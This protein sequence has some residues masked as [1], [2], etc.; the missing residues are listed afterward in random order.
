M[1][2]TGFAFLL[3]SSLACKFNEALNILLFFSVI[4]AKI[5][6][7]KNNFLA[8]V[9]DNEDTFACSSWVLE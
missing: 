2:T 1:P 8:T 3:F 5:Q 9:L 4:A 7:Q 6:M